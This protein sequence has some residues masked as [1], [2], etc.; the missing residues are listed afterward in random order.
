ME[1]TRQADYAV[2]TM[3]DL[4]RQPVGMRVR[5]GEIAARQ[6][7]PPTFLAKIVAQ[8]SVAGLLHTT[9]GAQGGLVLAKRPEEITLLEVLETIDGPIVFNRCAADPGHCPFG[10]TCEVQQVWADL[11][12]TGTQKLGS[13]TFAQLVSR[14]VGIRQLMPVAA[15]MVA[16]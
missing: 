7:I 8:L 10:D 13:V 5:T 1:I 15:L 4:S 16:A 14:P 6:Q 3:L 12:N 11:Q 9:R 2:R